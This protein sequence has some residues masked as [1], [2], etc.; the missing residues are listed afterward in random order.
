MAD[1]DTPGE[2]RGDTHAPPLKKP[3]L[4]PPTASSPAPGTPID[5]LDDL[6][7]T[8]SHGN[9]PLRVT[10]DL[11]F[12]SNRGFASKDST[13]EPDPPGVIPGLGLLAAGTQPTPTIGALDPH[14]AEQPDE[15]LRGV[16]DDLVRQQEEG[17]KEHDDLRVP[18]ILPDI[19]HAHSE[20]T[21]IGTPSNGTLH[22]AFRMPAGLPEARDAQA[23]PPEEKG[24]GQVDEQSTAPL[25][26]AVSGEAEW[27]LDS[28][29]EQSSSDDSSSNRSASSEDENDAE[30]YELLNPEEQARIL[31]QG[32]FGSDDEGDNAKPGKTGGSVQVR[33]KNEIL[34]DKV[35][36]PNVTITATMKLQDLGT[37]EFLVGNLVVIKANISGEF[38]VL[39]SG[40]VLCLAD[41]TVIGTVAEPLGRVQQPYYSVRFNS[42]EEIAEAGVAVGTNVFYVEEYSR[43]AFTQTL[44]TMKGS[45]ASNI[46]DEEV[47]EDE[48]EFSDDE[49]E[50]EYKKR[51]RLGRQG[52]RGS[53]HASQMP[54][55]RHVPPAAAGSGLKYDNGPASAEVPRA[56]DE[57]YTPL[58]RPSNFHELIGAGDARSELESPPGGAGGGHRGGR[59]RD[60]GWSSRGGRGGR[61]GRNP[62]H[63]Q[64]RPMHDRRP[65]PHHEAP[66]VPAF[67]SHHVIPAYGYV[68]PGPPMPSLGPFSYPSQ[69]SPVLAPQQAYPLPHMYPPTSYGWMP[70]VPP[71]EFPFASAP[72]P[73]FV[74]P[75]S[76]ASP[77]GSLPAGAF[78]NP[79][80]FRNPQSTPMRSQ[81]SPP[82]RPSISS[83]SPHGDIPGVAPEAGGRS[84]AAFRAAQEKLD[85]LRSLKRAGS[86]SP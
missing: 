3:R 17:K 57:L 35:E 15:E 69:T 5:D 63:D 45:D 77:G 50:A 80:F 44:K 18:Q 54:F 72:Y 65:E 36:K 83:A 48:V 60:R 19:A 21:S 56:D 64:G 75:S 26:E 2:S 53:R 27:E 55:G 14:G 82:P 81:L 31:M 46:H 84:D 4:E 49:A 9:T 29:A 32:D 40:S 12:P 85:I 41:R 76:A 6:Y 34:E 7:G 24:T 11:T 20:A 66:P 13:P 43:R 47:G 52:G 8:P 10:S 25:D 58:A 73:P 86:G 16:G 74:P 59:G 79:A 22:D 1:R 23:V 33:T 67:V 28:S 30:D 71:A 51:G 61:G 78:V 37:V 70:A 62:R 42:K 39:E 68:P 38:Q